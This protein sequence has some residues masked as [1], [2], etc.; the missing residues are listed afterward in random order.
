[1]NILQKLLLFLLLNQ[2]NSMKQIKDMCKKDTDYD[3][4]KHFG[5]EFIPQIFTP[6]KVSSQDINTYG[7]VYTVVYKPSIEQPRSK[8]TV[9][10]FII[11]N[12]SEKEQITREIAFVRE[13]SE[14][15]SH[16]FLEFLDC[17][18]ILSETNDQEIEKV[19]LMTE[20][21]EDRLLDYTFNFQ[22][23]DI[24][25]RYLHY[26]KLIGDFRYFHNTINHKYIDP[27]NYINMNIKLHNIM[28]K[29]KISQGNFILKLTDYEL[30]S[31]EDSLRRYTGT[32]AYTQP[33]LVQ[34]E[35][36]VPIK[37]QMDIYSMFICIAKIEYGSQ[38]T[39]Y[40][41]HEKCEEESHTPICHENLL[42]NIYKYHCTKNSLTFD[43][44]D[45]EDIKEKAYNNITMCEDLI[46]L[47]FRELRMDVD[48]IDDAKTAFNSM[49]FLYDQLIE[50]KPRRKTKSKSLG[51]SNT[52]MSRSSKFFSSVK[53]KI[54]L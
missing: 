46:C 3:L 29:G 28:S 24:S 17:I 25:F 37:P 52:W 11:S 40:Y 21:L 7:K 34:N 47:I 31:K 9:K 18:Y 1:M 39:N 27:E 48:D 45:F 53:R 44:E 15:S 8:I 43:P 35:K 50:S 26:S 19:Y 23:S 5:R 4:Q 38:V 41:Q 14:L 32:N 54:I 6:S 20:K 2:I 13:F 42:L 10:E 16:R 51:R 33:S 36:F 49:R 22:N 30:M 12:D